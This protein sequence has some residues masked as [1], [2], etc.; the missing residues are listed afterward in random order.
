[1][2]I[3][4]INREDSY[5]FENMCVYIVWINYRTYLLLVFNSCCQYQKNHVSVERNKTVKCR[6]AKRKKNYRYDM[7][8]LPVPIAKTANSLNFSLLSSFHQ[9][10][11]FS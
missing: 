10:E 1:M 3:I 7:G 2:Y 11:Y 5:I 6:A 8:A 9:L 4:N